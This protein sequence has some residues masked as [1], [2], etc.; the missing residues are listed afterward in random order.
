V[1]G[2][3]VFMA[4]FGETGD[5]GFSVAICPAGEVAT[6]GGWGFTTD[7]PADATVGVN[8]PLATN[9]WSVIMGND[10]PLETAFHARVACAGGPTPFTASAARVRL[11]AT[12]RA[13]LAREVAAVK[14]R[15]K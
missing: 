12:Q 9:P 15:H 1:N 11:S 13:T 14:S 2:A 6:G 8:G 3:D 10:G 5:T 4:P 7:A